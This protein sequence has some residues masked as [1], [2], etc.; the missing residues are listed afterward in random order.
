M[1]EVFRSRWL[2]GDVPKPS[3]TS[4]YEP[5][6]PTKG[7]SVGFVGSHPLLASSVTADTPGALWMPVPLCLHLRVVASTHSSSSIQCFLCWKVKRSSRPLAISP[8]IPR[9]RQE[10]SGDLFVNGKKSVDG[11]GAQ[12]F[13]LIDSTSMPDADRT[14]RRNPV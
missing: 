1:S 3:E 14:D 11:Q 13:L 7:S 6:E 5:T 10:M 4:G 8:Q 9:R 2:T 12:D